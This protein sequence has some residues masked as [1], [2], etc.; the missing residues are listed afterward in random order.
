MV[1]GGGMPGTV[2]ND[3]RRIN[4]GRGRAAGGGS[5]EDCADSSA[6]APSA[7]N[8]QSQSGGLRLTTR[9]VASAV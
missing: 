9:A 7:P 2:A 6:R 3:S 5:L 4:H 8:D 1:T